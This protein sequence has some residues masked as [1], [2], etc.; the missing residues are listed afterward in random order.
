MK[1]LNKMSCMHDL[2]HKIHTLPYLSRVSVYDN[3]SDM[4]GGL[5]VTLGLFASSLNQDNRKDKLHEQ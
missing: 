2:G 5:D 4:Q 1:L 3:P